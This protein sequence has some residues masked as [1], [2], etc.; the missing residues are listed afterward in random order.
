V[1]TAKVSLADTCSKCGRWAGVPGRLYE[2]DEIPDDGCECGWPDEPFD[3]AKFSAMTDQA[4]AQGDLMVAHRQELGGSDPTFWSERP[5]L[6]RVHNTAVNRLVSPWAVLGAVLVRVVAATSYRV[7]LPP[8]IGGVGSLNLFLALVGVSGSGKGGAMS[9]AEVAV[10]LGPEP[11]FETHS[12]GS[13]QGIAHA[14]ARAAVDFDKKPVVERHAYSAVFTAEEIDHLAGHA[15][16]NGSTVLAELRRLYMGERLGHQY[17]DVHKRVPVE[18]HTYR[19]GFVAGVQPSRA[20]VLLDDADGGT[21]QRF[22][23]LPTRFDLPKRMPTDSLG[24]WIWQRPEWHSDPI[25]NA[26]GALAEQWAPGTGRVTMAVP[27]CVTTAIRGARK[28]QLAGRGDPLDGHRLLCQEKVAAAF[29]ILAGRTSVT[30]DDWRLADRLMAVSDA[31]RGEVVGE[32]AAKAAQENMQRGKADG[33]RALAADDV[34]TKAATQRAAGSVLRALGRHSSG[35]MPRNLLRSRLKAGEV[36]DSFEDAIELLT[37]S[38][39]VVPEVTEYRGQEST[40]YR[41]VG[42]QHK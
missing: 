9:V 13:G 25:P 30:E 23:W 6:L 39:Q 38:G 35:P 22:L 31:T 21:P 20:G 34:K 29:A 14:Y 16:Q 17:V 32:L 3:V 10:D 1:T 27:E 4:I 42:D 19:A 26:V 2:I 5:E 7:V 24:P 36:R 11:G 40:S 33:Q 18:P 28:A 8:L 41:L 15:K 12:L 37:A